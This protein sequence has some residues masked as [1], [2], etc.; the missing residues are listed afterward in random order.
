MCHIVMPTFYYAAIS[1]YCTIVA[2]KERLKHNMLLFCH[3]SSAAC[4]WSFWPRA[5][6]VSH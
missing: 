2:E 1:F 6:T 5:V 3:S 4:P